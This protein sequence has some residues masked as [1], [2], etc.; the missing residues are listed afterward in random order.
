[1]ASPEALQGLELY[2]R[3]PHWGQDYED[4]L[5]YLEQAVR[6][7]DAV[8]VTEQTDQDVYRLWGWRSFAAMESGETLFC[9][10]PN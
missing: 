3:H 4:A 6:C 8:L 9:T 7:N 1:M 10:G 2:V 5:R